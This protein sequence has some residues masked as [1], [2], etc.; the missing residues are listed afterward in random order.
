MVRQS[1]CYSG[2]LFLLVLLMSVL[3]CPNADPDPPVEAQQQ[4]DE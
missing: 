2:F 1:K 3:D 4:I